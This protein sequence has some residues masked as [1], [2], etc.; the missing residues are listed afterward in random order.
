MILFMIL[1]QSILTKCP[2]FPHFYVFMLYILSN[3]FIFL[4]IFSILV[5]LYPSE[6]ETDQLLVC[7]YKLFLSVPKLLIRCSL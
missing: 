5:P 3:T 2:I 1:K 4:Y 6:V 7:F